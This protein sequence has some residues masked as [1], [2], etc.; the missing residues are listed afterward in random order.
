[1]L[2]KGKII[3]YVDITLSKLS[4]PGIIANITF[5]NNKYNNKKIVKTIRLLNGN[6]NDNVI[7]WNINPTKCYIF[8]HVVAYTVK[9]KLLGSFI[10]GLFQ[11]LDDIKNKFHFDDDDIFTDEIKKYKELHHKK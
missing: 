2:E 5:L 7:V 9:D 11:N 1:L 10:D 3:R 4:I 8:E 6:N